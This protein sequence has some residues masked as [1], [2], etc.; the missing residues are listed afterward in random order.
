MAA[1]AEAHRRGV[2]QSVMEELLERTRALAGL[3]GTLGS[4]ALGAVPEPVPSA[5][6]GVLSSLQQLIDQVPPFTAELDILVQELH[7]KRL[8]VHALQ[9]ELTA[10]DRQ[11][12]V[13]ER[14]LKPLEGWA[15]QWAQLR[16]SLTDARGAGGTPP[17][18]RSDAQSD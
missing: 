7:A 12:D 10:F 17:D 16:G 4:G 1:R 18:A 2:L 15:H 13:L 3:V 5:V 11:L 9:A 14:S 8:T 6:T